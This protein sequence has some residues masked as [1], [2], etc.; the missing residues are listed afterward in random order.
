[1]GGLEIYL[2]L[3]CLI[4]V[5]LT[6]FSVC[7]VLNIRLKFRYIYPGI[8]LLA[9]LAGC[10]IM[11]VA[12]HTADI[13]WLFYISGA[14]LSLL[15]LVIISL[16]SRDMNAAWYSLLISPL[17]GLLQYFLIGK[18]FDFIAGKIDGAGRGGNKV[19]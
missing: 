18:L 6:V 17:L 4:I 7:R 10:V 8:Y 13:L 9:S 16:F 3:T 15:S 2:L 19:G 12:K 5:L 11:A 1:M 14:P